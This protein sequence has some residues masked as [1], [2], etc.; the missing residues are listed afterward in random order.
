MIQVSV[1]F[2]LGVIAEA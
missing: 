1:H 2:P